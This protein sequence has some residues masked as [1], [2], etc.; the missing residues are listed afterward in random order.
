MDTNTKLTKICYIKCDTCGR[1]IGTFMHNQDMDWVF[2]GLI[3]DEACNMQAKAFSQITVNGK[4]QKIYCTRCHHSISIKD[5]EIMNTNTKL[6]K[7]DIIDITEQAYENMCSKYPDKKDRYLEAK[8]TA[9][10]LLEGVG[11]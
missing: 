2:P 6:T 1:L 10:K 3:D 11:Q 5:G 8:E 4:I 7:K 9:I